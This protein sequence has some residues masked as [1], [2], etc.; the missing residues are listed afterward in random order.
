M[1]KYTKVSFLLN[2]YIYNFYDIY[3]GDVATHASYL[4]SCIW[5]IKVRKK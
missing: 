4:Y 5:Y 1:S 3:Y 2:Y